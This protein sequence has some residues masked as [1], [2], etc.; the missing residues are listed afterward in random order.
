MLYT[1]ISDESLIIITEKNNF[2]TTDIAT[3]DDI[4]LIV[5]TRIKRLKVH[6]LILKNASKVFNVILSSQFNKD[7]R[8]TYNGSTEIN[9]PKDN[10]ETIRIILNIIYNYNNTVSDNLNASQIL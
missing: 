1:R 4:T 2:T 3:D 7:Q 5:G 9:M 10:I 8:L 6:S